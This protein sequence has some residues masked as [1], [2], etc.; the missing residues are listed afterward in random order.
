MKNHETLLLE[1]ALRHGYGGIDVAYDELTNTLFV[2]FENGEYGGG[3]II[4]IIDAPTLQNTARTINGVTDLTSIV[5]DTERRK[6]YATDRNTNLLHVIEWN[7]AQKTVSLE[8]TIELENIDD[9]CGLAIADDLLYVSELIYSTSGNMTYYSDVNCYR[10]SEDFAFVETIDMGDKTVAISHESGE[11]ILYGGAYAYTT[12]QHLIKNDLDDPNDLIKKNIAAGVIG[13]ACDDSA[14]GRVFLTTYRNGGSVE[15]WDTADWAAEP[16]T[17]TAEDAT[18]IYD[19]NN[20][21]ST[22]MTNL[23]GLVVIETPKPPHIQIVKRD[24]V[25]TCISPESEDPNFVYTIGISDPNGHEN[26]WI[27]D[28]L[29]R[30][31]DFV[32]ASPD[33]PNHG[34]DLESHTYTWF[35]PSIDSYDPNDPNSIPGGDPNEYF[36]LTVRPNGWAEPMSSFTNIATVESNTAY[37][38]TAMET[39]V[40]CWGGDVIY[41]DPRAVEETGYIQIG[42]FETTWATGRNTGTSWEDAYRNLPDALARAADCGSE[43][44]VAGGTYRPA[45]TVLTDTFEIPAGVSVY[46]GFAGN[47]TSRDQ[48]DI[49][50]YPTIL[51]GYIDEST[52]SNTVITMDGNGALLDGFTVQEGYLRGIDGSGVSSTIANCIIVNNVQKGVN[53]QNGDLIMKWCEVYGNGFQG[54]QHEGNSY[55]LTIENW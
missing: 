3:N 45:D 48:R 37:D 1:T 53:C 39:N 21:D 16:N 15:M 35:V 31:V 43:V 7:P 19:V 33:D 34:Y 28:H 9:A 49:L 13:V 5:F 23:A 10:I 22:D 27:V 2:S 51:S 32:S 4:E 18:D 24:D 50:K 29:P 25:E 47:E 14:T 40:C 17:L 38:W 55:Q 41:V 42:E 30:E 20:L 46:G 11:N 26:M 52:L 54:I 36:T 12:Y 6:L 44:W 8:K